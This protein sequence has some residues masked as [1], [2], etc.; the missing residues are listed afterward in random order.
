MALLASSRFLTPE[1]VT[2]AGYTRTAQ[3]W[4][5]LEVFLVPADPTLRSYDHIFKEFDS[6]LM[7]Q[8]REQAYGKDIGQHSW[9]T[10]EDLEADISRLGITASTR[11]LDLGCG[12]GGTLT[13][14]AGLTKCRATGIDVSPQAIA[15][16][17]NRAASFG[18]TCVT[19]QQVD[20]NQPLPF[21][22]ASFEVAMSLDV[23]VHLEN[24][25]ALFREVARV[26]IPGGKFLFTDAGVLTGAISKDE[27]R[28]RSI[29]GH[30]QF[31]PPGFNE[32]AL[33]RAGFE[34][35]AANDRTAA[36]LKNAVGRLSARL[37]HREELERIEGSPNFEREQQFLACVLD[38]SQRKVLTRMSYLA[39][40][41]T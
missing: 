34:V 13:F 12:P 9:V 29:H 19:F 24:R 35:L 36:L 40:A 11:L 2:S 6:P 27:V 28:L 33:E 5:A 10:A 26:L 38:L 22:D 39:Q 25:A 16:A 30:T 3:F 31:V 7:R 4:G 18:L 41:A 21:A 14:A 32:R 8:L 17:Q 23:V 20:L 37:A 1:D 15:A